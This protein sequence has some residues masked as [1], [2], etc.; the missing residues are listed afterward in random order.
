MKGLRHGR[1]SVKN[2]SVTDSRCC[3]WK[4]A[5][6]CGKRRWWWFPIA[7]GITEQIAKTTT[8]RGRSGRRSAGSDG[9]LMEE[10]ATGSRRC[11]GRG[12]RSTAAAEA[13]TWVAAVSAP[14]SGCWS[15]VDDDLERVADEAA[16]AAT[17]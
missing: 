9:R 1:M 12:G 6:G 10:K 3:S 11:S 13:A 14:G 17:G 8:I 5:A 16:E 2:N 7:G 4:G 15:R